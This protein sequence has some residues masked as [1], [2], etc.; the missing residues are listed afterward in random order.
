MCIISRQSSLSLGR[1][2]VESWWEWNKALAQCFFLL[3]LPLILRITNKAE[4]KSHF[5]DFWMHWNHHFIV[6][7]MDPRDSYCTQRSLHAYEVFSSSWW[8]RQPTFIP[9][10]TQVL[11]FYQGKHCLWPIVLQILESG[12]IDTLTA[13]RTWGWLSFINNPDFSHYLLLFC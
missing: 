7:R 11:C 13:L 5:K 12:I 3:S 6:G 9:L 1:Q 10:E 4:C 8:C 2:H